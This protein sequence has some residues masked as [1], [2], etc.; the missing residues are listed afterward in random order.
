MRVLWAGC[1]THTVRWVLGRLRRPDHY[2]TYTI[3]KHH[4][5]RLTFG[6]GIG[7]DEVVGTR[8]GRR[9]REE[10][11]YRP[12]DNVEVAVKPHYYSLQVIY[13]CLTEIAWMQ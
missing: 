9:C 10:V 4:W 11:V 1:C 7:L 6:L 2:Y 5:G 12:N 3:C 8:R 13:M